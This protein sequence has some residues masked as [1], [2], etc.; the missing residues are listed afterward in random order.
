[1]QAAG[2]QPPQ[3]WQSNR[4]HAQAVTE[5]TSQAAVEMLPL[6]GVESALWPSPPK[7]AK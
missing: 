2:P 5:Q 1:M 7:P 4:S 6:L 3:L